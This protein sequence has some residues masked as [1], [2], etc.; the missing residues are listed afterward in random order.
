M[1]VTTKVGLFL[2][3]CL[4]VLGI[5]SCDGGSTQ[6]PT[7]PT[8]SIIA[9]PTS[10]PVFSTLPSPQTNTQQSNVQRTDIQQESEVIVGGVSSG[11][12]GTPMQ[13][14]G[15]NPDIQAGGYNPNTPTV[16]ESAGIEFTVL[17]VFTYTHTA[18]DGTVTIKEGMTE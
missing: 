11:G 7:P 9:T 18:L 13:A 16:D 15:Y 14:G 5:V 3:V 4:S 17:T 10:V 2:L 8:L 1:K 12:N 6:T